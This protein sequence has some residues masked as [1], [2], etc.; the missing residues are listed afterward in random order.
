[1]LL[2][3]LH[4][5]ILQYVLNL[6][7]FYEY[8][9]PILEKIINNNFIFDI[10]PHLTTEE[11]I[12]PSVPHLF[13]CKYIYTYLDD[14]MYRTELWDYDISDNINKYKTGMSIYFKG[15]ISEGYSYHGNGNLNRCTNYVSEKR[16]GNQ[17]YYDKN[18]K[19]YKEDIYKEGI[20]SHSIKCKEV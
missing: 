13:K 4:K 17:H 6:Y 16:H 11:K 14:Y 19:K 1:M 18:G 15:K 8:E 7:L 3:Y 2:L 10:K 20:Y 9:I 5:D 12:L